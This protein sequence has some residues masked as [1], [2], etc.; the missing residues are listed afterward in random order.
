M[1]VAAAARGTVPE[2]PNSNPQSIGTGIPKLFWKDVIGWP[3]KSTFSEWP[4]WAPNELSESLWM[5]GRSPQVQGIVWQPMQ[6]RE[7]SAAAKPMNGEFAYVSASMLERMMK[8]HWGG[9]VVDVDAKATFQN[10]HIA[11]AINI[12]EDQIA[13]LAPRE[14]PNKSQPI[15]V[16][17]G[18]FRS[19]A[20]IQA[21]REF[22]KLG[23]KNVYDYRGGLE[24]WAASGY[25][26]AGAQAAHK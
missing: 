21:A 14:I 12:A 20:S 16:C 8:S 5:S 10:G 9:V 18:S 1:S 3:Y 22:R 13:A 24:L 11:G 19:G 17:C 4:P 15:V 7:E 26:T 25:P 23:Y 6:A 2:S